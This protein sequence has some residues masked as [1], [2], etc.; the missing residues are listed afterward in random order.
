MKTMIGAA[1]AAALL[2]AGP[3]AVRAYAHDD[4]AP[5]A[6]MKE[7]LGLTDDQAAKLKS[8]MESHRESMKGLMRQQ[9]DATAKLHDLLEDKASDEKVSAA[10]DSLKAAHK[11]IAAAHEKLDETL[12]GFLTPTQRAKMFLG[13]MA[14]MHERMGAPRGRGPG[15][16]GMKGGDAPPPPPDDGKPGDDE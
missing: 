3:A 13:M 9:R 14:R 1:L 6:E 11:Q 8:A 5:G 15:R 12:A 2:L 16:P 4:D 7:K 10:L